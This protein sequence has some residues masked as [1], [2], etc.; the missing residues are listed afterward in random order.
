MNENEERLANL[1][2]EIASIK[3]RNH[4]V[5]A[6]KAWEI[7]WFRL[8]L[9]GLITFI[10]TLVVLYVS[11]ATDVFLSSGLGATGIILSSL[12]LPVIKKWWLERQKN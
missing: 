1:E 8:S 7:S 12:T 5:E 10:F 11:G 2:R 4:R 6:D 9:V 3:A